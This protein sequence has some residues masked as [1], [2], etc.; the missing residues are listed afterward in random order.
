MPG[1]PRRDP[2]GATAVCADELACQRG[3]P[4]AARCIPADC[5][6]STGMT[7]DCQADSVVV[8]CLIVESRLHDGA[9]LAT[10]PFYKVGRTATE[11][12]AARTSA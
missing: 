7:Q 6:T 11:K 4:Y 9:R 12:P 5:R 3:R 1:M 8:P 10:A 2:A